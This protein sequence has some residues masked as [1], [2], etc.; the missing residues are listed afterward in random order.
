MNENRIS[1]PW[2]DLIGELE[3]EEGRLR[4]MGTDRPSR[5]T[6]TMTRG[7]MLG[8]GAGIRAVITDLVGTPAFVLSIVAANGD[9]N[10]PLVEFYK[11]HKVRITIESF[12]EAGDTINCG[13]CKRNVTE[14]ERSSIGVLRGEPEALC[15]VCGIDLS[16]K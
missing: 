10:H 14:Q 8:D 12:G 3:Q 2:T 15:P 11:N 4:R 7:I 5:N 1:R 9:P 6:T 16:K 13:V